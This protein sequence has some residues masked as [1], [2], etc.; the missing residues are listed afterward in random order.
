[1]QSALPTLCWTSHIF[2]SQ[3]SYELSF[4]CCTRARARAKVQS[5]SLREALLGFLK[6]DDVPDRLE[7]LYGKLESAYGLLF[8]LYMSL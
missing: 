4:Q 2:A 8:P 1:M 6:V 3:F 5:L 7:V